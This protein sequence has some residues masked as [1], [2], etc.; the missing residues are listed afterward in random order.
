MKTIYIARHAEAVSIGATGVHHDFD[1]YLTAQGQAR[2][3]RQARALARIEPQ[4]QVCFAS[5]LV[6]A[7]QTAEALV[8]P[9]GIPVE[10]QDALGSRP[11][12]QGV[13]ELLAASPADRILLVTHQPFVVQLS[14]WLLTGDSEV[15]S[16]FGTAAIACLKLHLLNPSPR[17]ELIWLMPSEFLAELDPQV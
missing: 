3:E 14:S 1:R 8:E 15:S 12:L 7:R 16:Q 5:P 11:D 2:L 9:Y 6:R 10:T 17:G 4:L 13:K